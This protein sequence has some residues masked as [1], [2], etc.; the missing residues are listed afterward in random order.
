MGTYSWR[1]ASLAS[2]GMLVLM[3]SA[4]KMGPDYVRPETPKADSWRVPASTAESIANLAW[5]DL[6]KDKQLQELHCESGLVGSSQRQ[7][8][9]RTDSSC[10]HR[11]SGCADSCRFGRTVSC[12][13]R[14]DAM[15]LGAS[16]VLWGHGVSVSDAGRQR[17]DHSRRRWSHRHSWNDRGQ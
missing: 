2:V 1:S 12:S 6:L 11:E 16:V 9:A 5:W 17:H 10:A 3:V 13:A 4:C 8:T 15:G 7:A 14:D